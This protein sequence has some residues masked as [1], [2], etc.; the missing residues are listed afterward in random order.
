VRPTTTSTRCAPTASDRFRPRPRGIEHHH[1]DQ[2]GQTEAVSTTREADME[3]A[4]R[5]AALEA[6]AE[7]I[8]LEDRRSFEGVIEL[9]GSGLLEDEWTLTSAARDST[10]LAVTASHWK[11]RNGQP[12]TLVVGPPDLDDGVWQVRVTY[13]PAGEQLL[14]WFTVSGPT[15]TAAV[16]GAIEAFP[17]GAAR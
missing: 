5:I 17:E 15:A 16:V 9:R 2:R 4:A 11:R 7:F 13:M 3:L 6:F 1:Q 14:N 8:P 12:G 10:V